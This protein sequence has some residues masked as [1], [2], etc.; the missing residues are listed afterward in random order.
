VLNVDGYIGES[1]GREIHYARS[2]GKKIRYLEPAR[3]EIASTGTEFRFLFIGGRGII[4]TGGNKM[5]WTPEERLILIKALAEKSSDRLQGNETHRQLM[6]RILFL[7]DMPPEFLE[8][9][10]DKYEDAIK[11]AQ[12][13]LTVSL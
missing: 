9:N 11:L 13:D 5:K 2:I 10:K 7:C 1:T 6:E 12:A 8:G 3:K 4:S